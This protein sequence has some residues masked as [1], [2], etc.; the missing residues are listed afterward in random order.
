M[1]TSETAEMIGQGLVHLVQGFPSFVILFVIGLLTTVF[2]L[3]MSNVAA[4]VLLVP[5]VLSLSGIG[6]LS[7]KA[8]VLQVGV[9]AANSFVLPTH[10][11]NALLMTP[12]GYQ[13]SDYLRAGSMLSVLFLL[14]STAMIYFL[15]M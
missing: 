8:L 4:T 7:Q 15:Y 11:V 9:C 12:G 13:I 6:G 3:I 5:L 2:S 1:K 14:V 10:H